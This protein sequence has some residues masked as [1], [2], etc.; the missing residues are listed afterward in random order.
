[1]LISVLSLKGSPGATTLA[2]AANVAEGC[3]MARDAAQPEP[4]R[5]L[6]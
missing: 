6:P 5:E 2:Y 3:R 1:M 4:N